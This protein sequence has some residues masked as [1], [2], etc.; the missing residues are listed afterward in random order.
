ML[1][2]LCLSTPMERWA[3]PATGNRSWSETRGTG[4]P[5]H[6]HTAP[7]GCPGFLNDRSLCTGN[8]GGGGSRRRPQH[9][10]HQAGK[11]TERREPPEGHAG[12]PGWTRRVPRGGK[13]GLSQRATRRPLGQPPA[14]R[15][16]HPGRRTPT[17]TTFSRGLPQQAAAVEG[18]VKGRRRVCHAGFPPRPG[19]PRQEPS[20]WSWASAPL[21]Q[22]GAAPGC[23]QVTTV[24]LPG[25]RPLCAPRPHPLNRASTRHSAP[26][27]PRHG[28]PDTDHSPSPVPRT[29]PLATLSAS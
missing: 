4:A 8:K 29:P 12:Q 6:L 5:A 14:L 27:P 2:E 9:T 24:E 20:Q 13:V 16:C 28:I 11:G 23:T 22:Q 25:T 3:R 15:G 19:Q 10:A 26:T 1:Q 18:G 17:G 21:Q 7:S